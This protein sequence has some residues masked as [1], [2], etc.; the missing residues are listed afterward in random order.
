MHR[1][2]KSGVDVSQRVRFSDQFSEWIAFLM[3]CYKTERCAECRVVVV[4]DTS[5][6]HTFS[7]EVIRINGDMCVRIDVTERQTASTDS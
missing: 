2:F 1:V 4:V 3:L 7:D 5:E 6:G